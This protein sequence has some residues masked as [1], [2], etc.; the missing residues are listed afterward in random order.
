LSGAER[1]NSLNWESKDWIVSV[2]SNLMITTMPRPRSS[3][4]AGF[5][6]VE[7]LVVIV[8][9]SVMTTGT[10]TLIN[11][12]SVSGGVSKSASGISQLL[13]QARAYAMAKHT[14][15]YLGL[16]DTEASIPAPGTGTGRIV[17][18]VVTSLDG[19]RPYRTGPL[20]ADNLAPISRLCYFT[21]TRIATAASLVNGDR[22][23]GRPTASVDMGG[24]AATT[25]F[26]WPLTGA[27][28]YNFSRVIEFDPQGVARVQ[29]GGAYNPSIQ[30]QI[31]IALSP[32][33]GGA[34]TTTN[35][36]NQAA[37]QVDGV[38]GAVRIYRP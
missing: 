31:E 38:T 34:S 19:T 7:L 27:A 29:S 9:I 36:A 23:K 17:V 22:M 32:W 18:A 5:S 16:T 15:V 30:T 24:A 8:V 11:S 26:T 3:D 2:A 28:Q 37:V 33:N 12:L 1:D 6:L 35:M 25:T 21:N 14:Y 13:E 10:A 4:K 20:S